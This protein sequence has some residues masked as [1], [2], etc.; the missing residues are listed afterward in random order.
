MR[1][2]ASILAAFGLLLA[3]AAA[4][5]DAGNGPPHVAFYVDGKTTP[6][7]TVGTP[8]DLSGTG[9]PASSF[10]K[11]YA[12]GGRGLLDVAEA[13]PGDT[14]YNGGRWM[15]FPVTWNVTPY[16]LFSEDEVLAAAAAGDLTIASEPAKFFVCPVIPGG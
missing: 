15:V 11:L 8:T 3:L 13:A 10:D 2:L 14:D 1:R 7:R 16:Q 5:A 9:A 6:Y 12:L 4:P